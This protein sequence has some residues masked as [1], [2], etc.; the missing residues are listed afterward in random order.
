M[1]TFNCKVNKNGNL[2][3]TKQAREILGLTEG[4]EVQVSLYNGDEI[5]IPQEFLDE[6]GISENSPL[7]VYTENGRVVVQEVCDD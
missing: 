3:L 2:K 5:H 7:E 4:D 1:V 6:A